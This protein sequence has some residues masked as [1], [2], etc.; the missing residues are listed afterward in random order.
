MCPVCLA[1][2]APVIAGAASG[3]AALALVVKKLRE[4]HRKGENTMETI[5]TTP[6][7][8][9]SR[10]EWREARKALLVEE[11]EFTR[12]R[13]ELTAYSADRDRWVRDRDQRFR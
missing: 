2:A 6:P 7:K 11:K 13:D 12:R 1:S 4:N 3:G 5:A 8:V 10:E 9:V